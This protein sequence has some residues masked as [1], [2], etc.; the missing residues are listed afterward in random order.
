MQFHPD[1]VA[2]LQA[3][4]TPSRAD[5]LVARG[6][7]LKACTDSA[8]PVRLSDFVDEWLR[9]NDS[10]RPAERTQYEVRASQEPG[11][12]LA[13]PDPSDPHLMVVRGKHAVRYAVAELISEGVL[14]RGEGNVYPNQGERISVKYPGGGSSAEVR[15]FSPRIAPENDDRRFQVLAR[16]GADEALLPVA[17]MVAGVEALLGDRG[18]ELVHESRRALTRGL[19]LASSTLLAATSEAAWFNLALAVA[20]PGSKLANASDEGLEIAQVIRQ[21]EQRL[22]DTKAPRATVTEVVAMAHQFREIRN[23]A[24]HPR[25]AR[26][27]HHETWL[28]QTGATILAIGARSYFLK[29]ESLRAAAL[30]TGARV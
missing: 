12:Q 19:F 9:A 18:I 27:D 13:D 26:T 21:S 22:R 7:V 28:G 11:R 8:E 16:S 1:W 25:E 10:H 4:V 2:T 6:A 15:V 29:L 20:L 17:E 30:T 24:L 3:A 5:V 23:Y 14:T